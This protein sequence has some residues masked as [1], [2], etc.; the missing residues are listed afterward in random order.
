M[1]FPRYPFVQ[2]E[3]IFRISS[4][5]GTFPET[6]MTPSTARAGV[7]ITPKPMM[8]WMSV[9]FSI[10]YSRPRLFAASSVV[11]ASFLHLVH[12]VPRICS[13]FM[14]LSLVR[15]NDD[16]SEDP[17]E[18]VSDDQDPDAHDTGKRRDQPYF[19]YLPENNH[20][21][22]GKPDDRHHERKDGPQGRALGQQRLDDRDDPRGVGI[23][24]DA[25]QHG[26]RN[27][28]P[29][30]AAHERRQEVFGHVPVD[31][32]ADRDPED[33]VYPDLSHD[34]ADSLIPV[35]DAI[36]DRHR[37][38]LGRLPPATHGLVHPG[39][40][41]FLHPEA[42]DRPSGDHRDSETGAEI[43]DRDLPPEQAEQEHEGDLV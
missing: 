3:R 1:S 6:F 19:Q 21:R 5:E 42:A 39:F 25:D 13:I 8:A 2:T 38:F 14:F 30:A 11:S 15:S 20:F 24:R 33:D 27:G 40:H 26:K 37:P 41:V 28:P 16:A 9:T 36:R 10:R 32:R 12:P 31:R 35:P 18:E 43:K 29:G 22:Q 4:V 17:I 7:I 23:H 34:V